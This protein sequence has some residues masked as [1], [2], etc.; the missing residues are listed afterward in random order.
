MD[1]GKWKV[2]EVKSL[3]G[4]AESPLSQCVKISGVCSESSPLL[5]FIKLKRVVTIGLR[6]MES[7]K[8]KDTK[9][10]ERSGKKR[11]GKYEVERRVTVEELVGLS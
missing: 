2:N 1:C 11:S 8:W 5:E 10:K 7:T 6:K 4:C 3:L 9:W